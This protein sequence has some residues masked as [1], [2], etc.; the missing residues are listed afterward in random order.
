MSFKREA[1]EEEENLNES[2]VRKIA[3]FLSFARKLFSNN[4]KR[5]NYRIELGKDRV[6]AI[7]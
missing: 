6:R 5:N 4:L 7:P 1:K 3:F 2:F